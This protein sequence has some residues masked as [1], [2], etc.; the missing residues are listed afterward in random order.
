VVRRPT[1]FSFRFPIS[2]IRLSIFEGS[3]SSPVDRSGQ[4]GTGILPVGTAGAAV[5][6]LCIVPLKWVG[7][8]AAQAL[9]LQGLCD[10]RR[11]WGTAQ[12]ARIPPE[13]Y[14]RSYDVRLRGRGVQPDQGSRARQ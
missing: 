3:G 2:N 11:R 12:I 7:E 4:G 5:S 1:T 9:A 14:P 6:S 13:E 8:G 10:H